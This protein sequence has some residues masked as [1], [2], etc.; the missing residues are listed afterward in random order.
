MMLETD[1]RHTEIRNDL[2]AD[3]GKGGELPSRGADYGD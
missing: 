3:L 1:K 2:P